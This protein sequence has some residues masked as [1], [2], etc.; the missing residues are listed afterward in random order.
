M[1]DL[2]IFE[3]PDGWER[4]KRLKTAMHIR[5][6]DEYF[7]S[8][9]IDMTSKR[10][11]KIKCGAEL[12]DGTFLTRE[13]ANSWAERFG[14]QITKKT[15]TSIDDHFERIVEEMSSKK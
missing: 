2:E 12:K 9:G 7:K 13:D 15:R 4:F 8:L 14:L 5:A 11:L 3:G 6:V 1:F 10:S